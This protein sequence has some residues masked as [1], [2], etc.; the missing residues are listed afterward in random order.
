MRTYE[1]LFIINGSISDNDRETIIA[2]FDKL[3]ADKGAEMLRTVRWG[4]RQLAY[5]IKKQT[6][7]Y[8]VIFYFNADPGI[9]RSYHREMDINENILRYMTLQSDGKHPDY[10][11]DEGEPSDVQ[12]SSEITGETVSEEIGDENENID[13]DIDLDEEITIDE[14]V[15]LDDDIAD[16]DPETSDET[17]ENTDIA[18]ESDD[19]TSVT[20]NE[21]ENTDKET[22]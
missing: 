12:V 13:E 20:D 5:E 19:E 10:I 14:D 2:R 9:I 15:D 21:K 18:S 7:G 17:D 3:L 22:E 16:D 8:Y 1:T 6:R 4:K 11:R